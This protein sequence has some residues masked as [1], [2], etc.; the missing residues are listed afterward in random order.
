[1]LGMLGFDLAA[2]TDQLSTKLARLM[3]LQEAS[4]EQTGCL[5]R[6]LTDLLRIL[7]L[8]YGLPVEG[9]RGHDPHRSPEVHLLGTNA[10]AAAA[11][12]LSLHGASI[13]LYGMLGK[14]VTRGF[15][16]NLGSAA[17]V[18]VFRRRDRPGGGTRYVLATSQI[19]DISWIFDSLEVLEA[20]EGPVLI[21]VSAQ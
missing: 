5:D 8:E 16:Q 3:N 11:Y 13:D 18:V 15:V 4:L 10:A 7:S 1:M 9:V 2:L 6:R 17:A 12:G 21:Q 19:L 20:G 14:P